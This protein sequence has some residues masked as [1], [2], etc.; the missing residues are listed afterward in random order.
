MAWQP[1]GVLSDQVFAGTLRIGLLLGAL[2]VA[3][4]SLTLWRSRLFLGVVVCSVLVLALWPKLF[5]FFAVAATV[6]LAILRP[7]WGA[8]SAARKPTPA[9]PMRSEPD[10]RDPVTT[11]RR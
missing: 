1:R 5:I 3:L 2:W 10:A 11:A 6:F 4:P 8:P 7:R 9:N